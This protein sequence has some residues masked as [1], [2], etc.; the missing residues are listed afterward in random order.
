MD[1]FFKGYIKK[2][3]SNQHC[4]WVAKE[5][6]KDTSYSFPYILPIKIFA[7]DKKHAFVMREGSAQ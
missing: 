2:S 5:M 7:I 1:L 6:N 4:N 3:E